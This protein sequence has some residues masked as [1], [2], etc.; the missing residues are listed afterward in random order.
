MLKKS[1]DE[2]KSEEDRPFGS[3]EGITDRGFRLD[4]NTNKCIL[5]CE[6]TFYTDIRNLDKQ[7]CKKC[8]SSCNSCTDEKPCKDSKYRTCV[9]NKSSFWD[10]ST[11]TCELCD[12]DSDKNDCKAC[13]PLR[14]YDCRDPKSCGLG[15]VWDSSREMSKSRTQCPGYH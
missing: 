11:G 3:L 14:K 13:G 5:D 7:S 6:M 2:Y 1:N 4:E 10:S 9:A 12:G 8:H 15:Y